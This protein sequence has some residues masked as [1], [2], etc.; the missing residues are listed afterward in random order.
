M[1]GTLR[2]NGC[3][4]LLFFIYFL[5]R[6]PVHQNHSNNIRPSLRKYRYNIPPVRTNNVLGRYQDKIYLKY[7]YSRFALTNTF[8]T[9]IQQF[10]CFFYVVINFVRFHCCTL[11]HY[12]VLYSRYQVIKGN[13]E[14]CVYDATRYYSTLLASY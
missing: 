12:Y 5:V 1:I 14:I 8:D 9:F 13:I 3:W 2:S 6:V 11:L 4:M 10:D 7:I